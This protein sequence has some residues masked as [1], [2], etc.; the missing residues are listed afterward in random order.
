MHNLEMSERQIGDATVLD[1]SG[2]LTI[3]EPAQRLKDKIDSLIL[4]RRTDIVLNLSDVSYVDSGGLGQLVSCHIAM[5][6][7]T[8][9]LKLL[10]VTN[11]T[12]HLLT[13]THL[14]SLFETFESEADAVQSF[15]PPQAVSAL[16]LQ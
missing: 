6:K 5:S 1:L 10:H 9:G 4:G 3:G 7:T 16:P 8:G 13:I 11:R 14:I 15:Q 12:R 2:R